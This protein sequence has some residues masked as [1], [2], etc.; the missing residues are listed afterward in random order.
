M[1]NAI[2]VLWFALVCLA[3]GSFALKSN[4]FQFRDCIEKGAF[5]FALG[6]GLIGYVILLI[7]LLRMLSGAVVL[8][9]MLLA[10]VCFFQEEWFWLKCIFRAVR[11][12][13]GQRWDIKKIGVVVWISVVIAWA[14]SLTLLPPTAHDA[15]SYQLD[16]PKRFAQAGGTVYLPYNL[17]S[18]FPFL[19]QMYYAAAVSIKLPE[20]AQSIHLLTALGTSI[21]LIALGTKIGGKRIGLL[22]A[23]VF[24]LTPGVF[25]QAILPLNDVAFCF[26]TFFSVY[27][28]LMALDQKQHVGRWYL[29]AGVFSGFA[30]STKHL[31]A[32][33]LMILASII[34]AVNTFSGDRSM[35]KGLWHVSL[36][37][38]AAVCFSLVWY[39]RSYFYEGNPV[40]PYF[41]SIF[42]GSGSEY[43]FTKAG[44]GKTLIDLILLPWRL[45]M[46]PQYFGGTWTRL[47]LIFL[48]FL[49]LILIKAW[50]RPALRI[51]CVFSCLY[52]L[53]W[54]YLAQNVRFLF[55][56]VPLL[57]LLVAYAAEKRKTYLIILLMAN[58]LFAFYHG[59]GGAQYLLKRESAHEY[60]M[61]RERTY[62]L[63]RW[64]NGNL[65][66]KAV[67]LSHGEMRAFYFEPLIIRGRE[68][69]RKSRYDVE[70][71]S[72]K[73][74]INRFRA[75]GITHL[76]L[77]SGWSDGI[78]YPPYHILS[79]VKDSFFRV[80]YLTF[81]HG[82][83]N[84]EGTTYELY[85]IR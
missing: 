64:I 25:N 47:G 19:I 69:Q 43:D 8:A 51:I 55:P 76:L 34:I 24:I 30:L 61:R 29:L 13:L 10:S 21:G 54:F 68:Y 71:K 44:F 84:L 52:L 39:L 22:A 82:E 20:L 6:F 60:L 59:R 65:D 56:I 63:S 26:F 53:V 85:K 28:F 16:L 4:R 41:T 74:T 12:E 42:G 73:D 66:S 62:S 36:Y 79:L 23:A 32:I 14:F 17:N 77:Q 9:I 75:D 7:G 40:Y 18:L 1:I 80:R 45:T 72:A 37:L 81:L 46:F 33:N 58:T 78:T 5:S 27:A 48:I 70:S 67:V 35:R 11:R 15:L 3:V 83:K 31:G 38:I 50:Q 49:P 2:I 57:S